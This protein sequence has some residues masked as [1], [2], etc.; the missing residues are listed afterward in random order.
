MI[1]DILVCVSVFF[2]R[3]IIRKHNCLFSLLRQL[4]SPSLTVV[5]N[6]CGTLW[7]L[8]ARCPEDQNTLISLGAIDM[9]RSLIHS[10][11]KMISVACS[12]A[13]KNLT[14]ARF[15]LSTDIADI[16]SSESSLL[17]RKRRP[18]ESEIGVQS[19][20]DD[21]SNKSYETQPVNYRHASQ[22]DD[23]SGENSLCGPFDVH[24]CHSLR[25]ESQKSKFYSLFG[26]MCFG[27]RITNA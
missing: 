7:N 22:V 1:N 10:K 25:D 20:D 5:S 6:A 4:S 14:N 11:H 8:S 26:N 3:V 17:M 2:F 23:F 15:D 27:Q 12:A 9:L 24:A 19:R 16:R 21:V 18:L 13:L